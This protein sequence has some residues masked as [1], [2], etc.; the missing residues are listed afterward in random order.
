MCPSGAAPGLP[1]EHGGV[2]QQMPHVS[3]LM[4]QHCCLISGHAYC[5]V[6]TQVLVEQRGGSIPSCGYH[7]CF[8]HLL[9]E[10]HEQ[11]HVG[12]FG[13]QRGTLDVDT[14]DLHVSPQYQW[15]KIICRHVA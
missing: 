14:G 11:L 4:M 9:R 7:M 13:A 8:K 1:R 3:T 12:L 5:D 10:M 6:A 15:P 2:L